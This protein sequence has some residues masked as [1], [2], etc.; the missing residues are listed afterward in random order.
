MENGNEQINKETLNPEKN[1]EEKKAKKEENGDD[2]HS[3]DELNENDKQVSFII[4]SFLKRV[5]AKKTPK[6]LITRFFDHFV[7]TKVYEF[8]LTLKL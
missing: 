4:F 5:L 1:N 8:F 7:V 3:K 6:L 2:K